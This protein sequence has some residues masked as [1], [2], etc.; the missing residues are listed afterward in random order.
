[1]NQDSC[2][3][4][5]LNLIINGFPGGDEHQRPYGR[6]LKVQCSRLFTW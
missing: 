5:K 2:T 4:I 3:L 6:L 1:M